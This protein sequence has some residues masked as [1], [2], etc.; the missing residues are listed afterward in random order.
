MQAD[1]VWQCR[2]QS[3]YRSSEGNR[4]LGK[5]HCV[6]GYLEPLSSL[7]GRAGVKVGLTCRFAV[8]WLLQGVTD[9]PHGC[10]P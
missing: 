3:G 9:W 5:S 1:T 8:F 2:I 10:F 6:C 4:R 7:K